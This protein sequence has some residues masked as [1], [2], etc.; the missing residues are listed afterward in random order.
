MIR[1]VVTGQETGSVN[2]VDRR[3][4]AITECSLEWPDGITLYPLAG[5][6]REDPGAHVESLT[7]NVDIAAERAHKSP[8]AGVGARAGANFAV[9]PVLGSED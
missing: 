3:F 9:W 8:G 7:L 5:N 1:I 4:G 2:K 6:N